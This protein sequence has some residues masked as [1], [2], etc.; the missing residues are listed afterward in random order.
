M[1]NFFLISNLEKDLHNEGI[2]CTSALQANHRYFPPDLQA[3]KGLAKRGD[4][5][6]RQEG[7]LTVTVWQDKRLV[8][9]LSTAHNPDQIEVV[10]RKKVDG[11]I[12]H[13]DCPVD[14]KY[15]GGVDKGDQLRQ[16]YYV[17]V[18]SRKSYK[19]IF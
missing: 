6:V 18:K 10:K 19:Y 14:Y 12:V 7:N 16:Y 5:V 2:Y 11:S 13:V 8:T 15:M 17:R 9:S 4:M 3:C 1:D